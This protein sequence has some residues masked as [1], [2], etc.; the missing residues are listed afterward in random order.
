[1]IGL[2]SGVIP[3]YK[4]DPAEARRL[5]YVGMTRAR[6]EVHLLWSGFYIT[7]R[8]KSLSYG[9]SPFLLELQQRLKRS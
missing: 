1:M 6:R 5:F 4:K 7:S 3:G 8:R 9:P 2:E